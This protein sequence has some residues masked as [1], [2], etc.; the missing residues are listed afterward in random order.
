MADRTKWFVST[1]WLATHA[2]DPDVVVADGSWHLPTTGR[3]GHKEYLD[4][5]IPG[6]VFFDIDAIADTSNPLPHMLPSATAFAEA[7]GALGIDERQKIVAYDPVG[8]SSAPRVWWTFR[9]MGAK[10]VVILD[11]GFAKWRSEKRPVESG[12]VGRPPRKFKATFNAATVRDLDE[13]RDGIA[14]GAMQVVDARPAARFRGEAPEPRD[15]VKSGHIPGS[16]SLPSTEITAEGTLKDPAAIRKAFEAAGV[17][18]DKPIVTS[19]GSGVN[20]ATLT[21]ALDMI[22]VGV[23]RTALY[24]GSWTEWG[25]RD[26]T[27]IAVGPPER[28]RR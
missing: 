26:D 16:V 1:E 7:V 8:L 18:L 20:A 19:C 3:S 25:G 12:K 14:K 4:A 27:E 9:I 21:L 15:W 28:T 17:D 24:D 6:A 10:D 22:G 11:G 2:G 23:E 5:H 13:I